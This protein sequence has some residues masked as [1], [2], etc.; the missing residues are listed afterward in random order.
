MNK[1]EAIM[2]TEYDSLTVK[3]TIGINADTLEAAQV[4]AK[5]YAEDL[6]AKFGDFAYVRS[7]KEVT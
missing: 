7:V 2:I 6:S 5:L 1:Y 3:K 4:S